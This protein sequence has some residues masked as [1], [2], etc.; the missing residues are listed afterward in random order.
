MIRPQRG[1]I[2]IDL[3]MVILFVVGVL[4]SVCF[5]VIKF[6]ID[7]IEILRSVSF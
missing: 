4:G 3:F 5:L 1:P 6:I 7:N 2:D